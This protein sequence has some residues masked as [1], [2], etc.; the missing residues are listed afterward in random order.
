VHARPRLTVSKVGRSSAAGP[1]VYRFEISSS[2]SGD[3]ATGIV[4]AS[5]DLPEGA[6]QTSWQPAA[7]LP[8]GIVLLW[9]VRVT[10]T[11]SGATATFTPLSFLVVISTSNIYTLAIGVPA[12]CGSPASFSFFALSD[13]TPQANHIV[14]RPT[15]P[16][17][18]NAMTM[19][20]SLTPSGAVSGTLI[21][22]AN[23][24]TI[25][26]DSSAR[27]AATVTGQRNADGTLSGTFAGYVVIF[28]NTRAPITACTSSSFSWSVTPRD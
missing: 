23:G 9:R 16:S 14:L 15:P 12:S 2:T 13:N 21:G 8:L 25:S 26:A 5:P 17:P 11:A 19:D 6:T 18:S 22:N 27:G 3:F 10:D 20:I 24:V 28:T 4:A 1:L 7:D